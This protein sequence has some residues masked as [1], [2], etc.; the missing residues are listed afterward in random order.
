MKYLSFEVGDSGNRISI[1]EKV[2]SFIQV[3]HRIIM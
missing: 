3:Y 1:G 2:Q